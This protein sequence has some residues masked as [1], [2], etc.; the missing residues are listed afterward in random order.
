MGMLVLRS[1]Q[2]D[3]Y[4]SY[5]SMPTDLTNYVEPW[6]YVVL[7]S[8]CTNLALAV[9]AL[10]LPLPLPIALLLTLLLKML[11][12]LPQ[13]SLPPWF[14]RYWI[15]SFFYQAFRYSHASFKLGVVGARGGRDCGRKSKRSGPSVKGGVSW[16]NYGNNNRPWEGKGTLPYTL[17]CTVES[18]PSL[19]WHPTSKREEKGACCL[20]W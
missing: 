9:E 8:L 17:A 5:T 1:E 12:S 13:S 20:T 11:I 4:T 19:R 7:T 6:K 10:P 14:F 16:A 15:S 2:Y 18:R 3:D